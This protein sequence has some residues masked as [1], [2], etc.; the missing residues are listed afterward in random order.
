MMPTDIGDF[1]GPVRVGVLITAYARIAPSA[2]HL[3]TSVPEL[4]HSWGRAAVESVVPESG[5][6][7]SRGHWGP[8]SRLTATA[9]AI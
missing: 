4:S 7:M 1:R 8:P 6:P 2:S 5:R 9:P 3:P